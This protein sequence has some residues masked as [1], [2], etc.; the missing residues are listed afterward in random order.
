MLNNAFAFDGGAALWANA[1]LPE[2]NHSAHRVRRAYPPKWPLL[3]F[4][5]ANK[6]FIIPPSSA[7]K[8]S[9]AVTLA[10]SPRAMTLPQLF[11]GS[12]FCSGSLALYRY[13]KRATQHIVV[14][15]CVFS[16]EY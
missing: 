9:R 12:R 16:D 6:R 15:D 13:L 5:R 2:H 7:R 3:W 4:F 10:K 8:T 14:S 11:R 1:P